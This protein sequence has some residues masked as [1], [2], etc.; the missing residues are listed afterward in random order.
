[1]A[2]RE[3]QYVLRV[4]DKAVAARIRKQLNQEHSKAKLDIRLDGTSNC[5]TAGGWCCL[6]EM[7]W[8]QVMTSMLLSAASHSDGRTGQFSFGSEVLPVTLLDL[9]CVVESYKTYD[10]SHLVKM[11]DIGQVRFHFCRMI[12]CGAA[13]RCDMSIS[14]SMP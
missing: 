7:C 10:D 9:P 3:E 5:A 13:A 11:C 4:Q 1:M 8:C 6:G 14:V 2:D 12:C